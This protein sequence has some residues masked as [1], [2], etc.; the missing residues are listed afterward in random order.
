MLK[1]DISNEVYPRLVVVFET[2]IITFD[3]TSR[4][5]FDLALRKGQWK[6]AL[7]N[8]QINT[9]VYKHIL[10]LS[11]RKHFTIDFVTFIDPEFADA[12]EE[13]CEEE[14]IPVGNIN[15]TTVE[16]LARQIA[17]RPDIAMIF[18]GDPTRA[19][20]YGSKGKYVNPSEPV[21]L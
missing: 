2:L 13:F 18:D 12:L 21:F 3:N 16:R 1:G 10:D 14:M 7:K 4:G 9:I 17:N 5:K 11:Y 19:F 6:K 8:A 20:A 15:F